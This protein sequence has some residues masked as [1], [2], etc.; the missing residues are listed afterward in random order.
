MTKLKLVGNLLLLFASV[1]PAL[2]G[3][4]AD[5]SDS[6]GWR[7]PDHSC[8]TRQIPGPIVPSTERLPAGTQRV[9]YLNRM[10]GTYQIGSGAT[11]SA[12]NSASS[13][14]WP[15]SS[16]PATA[17][18]PPL[19]SGFDWPKIVTCVKQ[20]YQ[21][22]NVRITETEPTTGMYIE[23]VVG[24]YGTEIGWGRDQLFGVASADNFCGVT[25][26]GIAFNFSETHRGIARQDDELCATIAHEVGHLLALEHESLP[27]DVMSYVEVAR[28]GTKAFIDQL[29]RCGTAPDRL[30][31]CTCANTNS[32]TNS[33][34]R[35]TQFLGLRSVET[36]P[37]QLTVGSPGNGVT[38]PPTFD[39]VV[40]AT[41]ETEMAD[42]TV[43]LDNVEAGS[44]AEPENNKY[45]I[46]VRNAAEG[47]H[48]LTIAAR[49]AAGNVTSKD[50][51]IT[52]KKASIGETCSANEECQGNLCAGTAEG[53]FCTQ[54][55]DIN[56]GGCPDDFLCTA[57][58][59]GGPAICVADPEAGGGC[60]CASSDGPTGA[61]A[62]LALG[63]GLV[64]SRRRRR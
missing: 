52:V 46:T 54:V 61:M 17:T 41:D 36:T 51:S 22:Y 14:I 34:A 37:P 63:V 8:G 29:S 11:N 47:P 49:D 9:V 35:L 40:T 60:G 16:G 55:C 13:M 3:P 43:S 25:E 45:K 64:L 5:G 26:R 58:G 30:S 32:Q 1:S 21:K 12:T 53:G 62:M 31:A 2:A 4:D 19:A 7:R 24:G 20:H 28:S 27:T 42:V 15:G 48:T 39:V 38:L 6:T 18:I 44:S 57:T 10:G 50:L 59:G 33:A 23:A 56:A